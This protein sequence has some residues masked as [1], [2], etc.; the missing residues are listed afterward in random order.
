[1]KNLIIALV[2]TLAI[3]GCSRTEQGAVV[4][5]TTGAILGGVAAG[6]AGGALVGGAVGAVAG[7]PYW[8]GARAWPLLLSRA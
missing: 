3:A 8:A 2:A 6:D 5:G 1:M 7:R 4:G